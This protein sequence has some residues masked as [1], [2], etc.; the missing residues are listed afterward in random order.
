LTIEELDWTT[1]MNIVLNVA[2]GKRFNSKEHILE[3]QCNFVLVKKHSMG[4]FN[5]LPIKTKHETIYHK[6]KFLLIVILS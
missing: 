4:N 5:F 6:G 1:R 2:Q 3:N